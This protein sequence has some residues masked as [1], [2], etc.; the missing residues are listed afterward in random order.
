MTFGMPHP[1]G[2]RWSSCQWSDLPS[3]LATSWPHSTSRMPTYMPPLFRHIINISGVFSLPEESPSVWHLFSLWHLTHITKPLEMFL[4]QRE[5]Q[6]IWY[7]NKCLINSP[8]SVASR[9]DR[10]YPL[11]SSAARLANKVRE[12]VVVYLPDP[13]L[14][15][16]TIG[17]TSRPPCHLADTLEL[18]ATSGSGRPVFRTPD[19][20]LATPARLAHLRCLQLHP[21]QIFSVVQSGH[22]PDQ[23]VSLPASLQP[24]LHWWRLVSNV[25][26]H[27]PSPSVLGCIERQASRMWKPRFSTRTSTVWNF[28]QLYLPFRRGG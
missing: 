14:H 16:G 28:K 24:Y 11:V 3:N 17:H 12:V 6:F 20:Q 9:P 15:R 10:I 21:L 19:S 8:S 23:V 7:I 1:P 26:L 25:E 4:H 18:V 22:V 2:F 5:I 13:S 27:S